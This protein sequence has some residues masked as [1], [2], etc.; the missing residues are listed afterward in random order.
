VNRAYRFSKKKK[1][2][3]P[4]VLFIFAF[5][6]FSIFIYNYG[7]TFVQANSQ[8]QVLSMKTVTTKHSPTPIPTSPTA[9]VSPTK[10]LNS[11]TVYLGM[12]TG[13]LWDDKSLSLHPEALTA[14]Q[15][16]ID[17]KVAIAH[18]YTGWSNLENPQLI[19]QL[20]TASN[21]GW[22]PMVSANPYFFDRCQANGKTLYQAISSGNCDDFIKSVGLSLKQYG[23]PIFLRF[24]WE[25]NIDSMDW[26]IQTTGSSPADYINA[27]RRFHDIVSA[28][29]ATN[30]LW[31]FAPNTMSSSSIAYNL[32][33]P[34][35]SYVDWIGLD[36]YNWGTTQLWSSWE[37]FA[38]TFQASYNSLTTIAPGKPL[39]LSEVNTTDVGGDKPFWYTDMLTQQIPYNFPRISAVVFYNEDR[40]QQEKV[41]WL[42]DSSP[43]SLQAFIQGISLPL[44]LSSF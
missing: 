9:K 14:V 15:N 18:F 13:G 3:R 30:V 31:V 29:G 38:K 22:R 44:Y 5:L 40:T 41:N 39:M 37:S 4:T 2:L 12:W 8:Q 11:H 42:I 17:K 35:D 27:W 1:V 24:A 21:N 36:G 23:K 34:G 7:K 33:Y 43:A 26:S 10:T 20:Q 25:M 28:Q 19:S 16:K 32:L 6:V